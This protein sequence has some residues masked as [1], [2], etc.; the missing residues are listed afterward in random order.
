MGK[1]KGIVSQSNFQISNRKPLQSP[2]EF[3]FTNPPKD[4]SPK[5]VN[6]N[7]N[8]SIHDLEN[9]PVHQRS[10]IT[11]AQKPIESQYM[12]SFPKDITSLFHG[13]EKLDDSNW[14]I[15]K[16][17]VQDNLDLCDLWDIVIGEEPRPHESEV[18]ELRS[19]IRREK[20]ARTIIKNAFGTND[21]SQV[22]F[23]GNFAEICRTLESL[24]QSTGAQ[25]KADLM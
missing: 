22:R 6:N 12:Y 25:G 1:V 21:Y 24:H 3:E 17:N 20:T 9:I 8:S 23:M 11:R 7:Q 16:G 19:W 13:I 2:D 18:E 14:F 5:I 10:N 4:K 15:W